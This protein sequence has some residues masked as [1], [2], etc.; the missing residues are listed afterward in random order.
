[1]DGNGVVGAHLNRSLRDNDFKSCLRSGIGGA[2]FSVARERPL[3]S[4]G[5]YL[6]HDV[7]HKRSP[8]RASNVCSRNL[9]HHRFG[10]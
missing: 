2:G 3:T 4:C 8:L 5:G 1:M 6:V 10:R 9:R 7:F